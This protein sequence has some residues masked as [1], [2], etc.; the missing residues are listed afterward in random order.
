MTS[1]NVDTSVN[2]EKISFHE[3]Y[4]VNSSN[5]LPANFSNKIYM[6][7]LFPTRIGKCDV[8][9]YN[10]VNSSCLSPGDVIEW[11]P[12][13]WN[14]SEKK[15]LYSTIKVLNDDEFC[16]N[17]SRQVV[18]HDE[19][20]T[21][22]DAIA[23]CKR[24]GNG[25]LPEP[26]ELTGD[27]SKKHVWIPYTDILTENSFVN[28]YNGSETSRLNWESGEPD[29]GRLENCVACKGGKQCWD[30]SCG[31]RYPTACILPNNQYAKF[32]GP[33][34]ERFNQRYYFWSHDIYSM[35]IGKRKYTII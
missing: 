28:S 29:G 1:G 34:S 4:L 26:G 6:T 24:L 12:Y 22:A 17:R 27:L 11:N 10:A 25:R 13:H 9:N 7:S 31:S 5:R 18:L 35:W 14:A 19:L 30:D 21:Y 3:P 33:A 20:F 32:R 23:V 15:T 8:Y 16:N 2:G